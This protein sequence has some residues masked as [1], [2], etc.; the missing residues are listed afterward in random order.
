MKI[1]KIEENDSG[2]RL[3]KFLK[4]LF[5]SATRSLIYKFNRK[6]KIKVLGDDTLGK[7]K[8]KD[9]DYKLSLGDEVKVFLTDEDFEEFK[10]EPK[11][12]KIEVNKK[13]DKSQIIYEDKYLLIV[14]KNSGVNVHPG[15]FKTKEISLID[16]I[17]DYLG[18][19]Y[20]SL[21]FKPSLV[22]RIDR[23]TSGVLLI[24]KNKKLLIKLVEDFKNH[25]NIKKTYIA[26]VLGKLPKR[27]GKVRDK[28]LR[29]KDSKDE[30]KVKI[31]DEGKEALTH[32]RVLKE[33]KLK[34]KNG[35]ELISKVEVEIET[36]RMHQIRV[37]LAYL[38][39]PVIGD[40]IYG[41]KSFNSYLSKEFGFSR[42]ALHSSKLEFFHHILDKKMT[43]KAN[44]K[45]DM[46]KFLS[47]MKEI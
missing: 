14:N 41:N 28:L 30:N 3:D 27:H 38:G 5:P 40:K 1:F 24:A 45:D 47:K 29:I 26:L 31:S 34:T 42:Q 21:T 37:H 20:D 46:T 23:D 7:Y 8:K 9:N 11:K 15:D 33:Y 36:G 6:N 44:L 19:K 17:Q 12:N 13:F 35:F 25:N 39:N 22:H 4:K 18:N 2:Q 16:Q 43:I 32:Y 10:K